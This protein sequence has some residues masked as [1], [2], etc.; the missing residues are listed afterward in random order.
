MTQQISH[1]SSTGDVG[2]D[3]RGVEFGIGIG[4]RNV[5]PNS[6][7]FTIPQQYA[8]GWRSSVSYQRGLRG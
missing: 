5:K 1:A 7:T 6:L 2:L 3:T 4:A 8:L